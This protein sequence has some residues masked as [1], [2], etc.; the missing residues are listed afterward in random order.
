M[1]ASAILPTQAK[2]QLNSRNGTAHLNSA[3]EQRN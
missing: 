3:S 1:I 2:P